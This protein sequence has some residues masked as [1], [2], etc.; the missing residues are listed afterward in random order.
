MLGFWTMKRPLRTVNVPKDEIEA[1]ANGGAQNSRKKRRR[2]GV[3]EPCQTKINCDKCS[4]CLN[5]RTGHQICKFRKCVEL[6]KKVCVPVI[7]HS[8][9]QILV[10][11]V[12]CSIAR[13][14]LFGEVERINDSMAYVFCMR[15]RC[16]ELP[17]YL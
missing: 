1:H 4:N 10:F 9:V 16:F 15:L 6:R 7:V 2:C 17:L 11:I 12:Y 3:C 8:F 5:R 13:Q 14:N